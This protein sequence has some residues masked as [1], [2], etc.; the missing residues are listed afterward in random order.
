[1][2]LA[3]ESP[4]AIWLRKASER[5]SLVAKVVI[6]ALISGSASAYLLAT[7][8]SLIIDHPA[9]YGD[10]AIVLLASVCLFVATLS[11]WALSF[12]CTVKSSS[13]LYLAVWYV[14]RMI[15]SLG[16]LVSFSLGFSSA[17]VFVGRSTSPSRF[18]SDSWYFRVG[19]SF[20][21]ALWLAIGEWQRAR[22]HK[23]SKKPKR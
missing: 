12:A 5:L 17:Y 1:M 21:L 4:A 6:L 22:R 19:S 14:I 8:K 10:N 9:S 15:A 13:K 7:Y 20:I 23:R 11:T 3:G 18:D 16:V 2:P